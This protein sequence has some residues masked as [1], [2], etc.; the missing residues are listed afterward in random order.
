MS[1]AYA[2]VNSFPT[3]IPIPSDGDLKNAATVGAALQG[4]MDGLLFLANV[5]GG[6]NP[7]GVL[8]NPTLKGLVS[9]TNNGADRTLD[10]VNM[11]TTI[12]DQSN[13]K[14]NGPA[15]T[16]STVQVDRNMN[17]PTGN[18]TYG[19]GLGQTATWACPTFF[20]QP[21]SLT[22]AGRLR[23]RRQN[24]ALGNF[25][26]AISPA[27]TD[28]Y[29]VRTGD[30]AS[31]NRGV[32]ANGTAD[33]SNASWD[34]IRIVSYDNVDFPLYAA[35]AVTAITDGQ[36]SPIVVVRDPTAAG[37]YA[38]VLLQWNGTIWEMIGQ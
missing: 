15:A 3:T 10:I 13:F 9:I 16:S 33:A 8:K 37:E 2:G 31:G 24:T 14:I 7:A 28:V 5:R 11:N 1:T 25:N 21:M 20:S 36:G 17:W 32:V 12:D 22:G 29:F 19:G 35:N 18:H 27:A 4:A 30:I 38:S 26:R 6:T 23:L 34:V